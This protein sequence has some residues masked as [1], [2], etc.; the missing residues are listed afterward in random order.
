VLLAVVLLA[1][2]AFLFFLNQPA[3][4]Q[5]AGEL[6]I[7]PAATDLDQFPADTEIVY[8]PSAG[9]VATQVYTQPL[10]TGTV[11]I[12][13]GPTDCAG[14]TCYEVKVTCPG[15]SRTI[16]ALVRTGEPA[17]V[18]ALGSI[19]FANGGTG[20]AYWGDAHAQ[21]ARVLGELRAAGYRTVEFKWKATWYQGAVG[22]QEGF[23]KLGC[24]PA[25]L[26]QWI[27]DAIHVQADTLPFCFYGHSNGAAALAYTATHYDKRNILDLAVFNGGPNW[28][29]NDIGCIQDDP[30]YSS[31]FFDLAGRKNVD[32][33]FGYKTDGT[34][35]CGRKDPAYRDQFYFSG[36]VS[37]DWQ[38]VYP[39][40][41]LSF[42]FGAN[43]KTKTANHGKHFYDT[44][45]TAGSP[46][47][48]YT[49]VAGAG[50]NT[51]T[52][53]NGANAIRDILLA[54]CRLH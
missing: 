31:L 52:T 22:K 30:A 47:V 36:I 7:S 16:N 1:I 4:A 14:L 2:L 23:V 13:S 37:S 25:T 35:P 6:E 46:L 11:T 12:V 34:G 48:S 19:L 26:A 17:G 32:R 38:Y 49:T 39:T 33:S 8:V 15:V 29:R 54:E 24:R 18:P 3:S 10:P 9:L 44:V 53:I 5:G 43:D 41:M 40:T 21:T 51:Y 45:V 20:A 27:Y 28:V 42:V 50:H